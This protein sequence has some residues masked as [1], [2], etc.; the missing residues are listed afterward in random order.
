MRI[1]VFVDCKEIDQKVF[2]VPIQVI[3]NIAAPK[4]RSRLCEF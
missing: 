1:F 3:V 2:Y 4:S